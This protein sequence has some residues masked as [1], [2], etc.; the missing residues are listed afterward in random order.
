LFADFVYHFDRVSSF[1]SYPPFDPSAYA[2]A[3]SQI[4]FPD[5]RRAALVA[6]L[7]I[8]NGNSELLT[9]LARP[10]TLAVVTGQ[11][12][13]LFSGPAYTI[14][15]ALTA[16]RVARE[17]TSRG[18]PAV[19]IFWLAT[20]D[21]DF[22]EVNQ[23]WTFDAA[24]QPIELAVRDYDPTAVAGRPVGEVAVGKY[25]TDALRSSL[26]GF[27]FG[28]QLSGLMEQSYAD[29]ATFGAAFETLL[30]HLL[31][32]YE[33]L[34]IDPMLPAVR[35][36]AAPAIRA[37]LSQAPELTADLLQ[38]NKELIAAGYHAQVHVEDHTSLV[39]LLEGGRR[40]AL[41]RKNGEYSANGRRFSTQELMDR[42]A[43]L[44]PNALLRPVA[45]D[46]ILPTV[47]YIG[48]PAELA[49]LA[50]SQV[51]YRRILG[52]M[53]VAL[54]R[55]GFTLFDQRSDKLMRRYHLRLTDFFHGTEHLREKVAAELIPPGVAQAM[56][57]AKAATGAAL[58]RL[59]AALAGFDP[60]LAA[61]LSNN[62]RK[63]EYQL[64]KMERKIGRE[65]MRRDE[66][67]SR[68]AAYLC[69]LIYPHKHLQERLYSIVPFLA[70]HG[71]D[72]VDRIYENIQLDCPDHRL[73]TV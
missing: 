16:V 28:D 2:S 39:F 61:A 63:I 5:D 36:L 31:P 19:P 52:R 25:P 56:A 6:A 71:L 58:D 37:A 67:A 23:C 50:Q 42:A 4:Q 44:S 30:K 7:R 45:Q 11:Q 69:N 14:Y 65:A 26:E 41:K 46:S 29:G 1:Y 27:P 48:G 60:T 59:N 35:E 47:A 38:R 13:G 15:K 3:A 62:R 53:P 51:I 20:E 43:S 17:L 12:V 10:G 24:Q 55:S 21:H 72:L 34:H 22:A 68:D 40:V 57:D 66:R 9:Q 49:Y 73:L 8:Q 70:K 54:P 32:G 33:L 64:S 18:I